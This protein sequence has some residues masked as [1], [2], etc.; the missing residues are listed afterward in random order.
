MKLFYKN[1]GAVTIFLILILVPVL[2]L[3]GIFVEISRVELAKPLITSSAD[4]ALNT[5][6]TNY[7]SKLKDYYGL[8]GSAQKTSDTL[9]VAQEYFKN[10]INSQIVDEDYLDQCWEKVSTV[11]NNG[12]K[13]IGRDSIIT[14][15]AETISNLLLLEIPELTV[16]GVD[17]ANLS[18]PV[19]LKSQIVEFMKYR[20]PVEIVT[21]LFEELKNNADALENLEKDKKLQ[22]YEQQT[23]EAENELLQRLYDIYVEIDSYKNDQKIEKVTKAKNLEDMQVNMCGLKVTRVYQQAHK[24][25]IRRYINI[26]GGNGFYTVF[27][28]KMDSF[29]NSVRTSDEYT[30][31]DSE[32]DI[33]K[34]CGQIEGIF[35]IIGNFEK[36]RNDMNKFD[37]Y[38]KTKDDPLQYCYQLYNKAP[39]GDGNINGIAINGY[40]ENLTSMWNAYPQISRM[41]YCVTK[42]EALKSQ[43]QGKINIPDT[44]KSILAKGGSSIE[45]EADLLHKLCLYMEKYDNFVWNDLRT[46]D[47]RGEYYQNV[48]SINRGSDD[49]AENLIKFMYSVSNS[50]TL[51]AERLGK[52]DNYGEDIKKL[53]DFM[54]DINTAVRDAQ[55]AH[56]DK[57][58]EM[59]DGRGEYKPGLSELVKKYS[60]KQQKW[61]DEANYCDTAGSYCAKSKARAEENR[62]EDILKEEDVTAFQKRINNID[63]YLDGL[64][65]YTTGIKCKINNNKEETPLWFVYFADFVDVEKKCIS[66]EDINDV[67]YDFLDKKATDTFKM[68]IDDSKLYYESDSSPDFDAVGNNLYD[69]MKKKFGEINQTEKEKVEKGN[70]RYKS[71]KNESAKKDDREEDNETPNKNIGEDIYK[72]FKDVANTYPSGLTNTSDKVGIFSSIIDFAQRLKADSVGTLKDARDSLYV[73]EYCMNMFSYASYENEMKY[74]YMITNDTSLKENLEKLPKCVSNGQLID[75]VMPTETKAT[76]D[77]LMAETNDNKNTTITANKTLT[78]QVISKDNN[79]A[80]QR[81]IEYLLYGNDNDTNIKNVKWELFKLRYAM[82]IVPG[83]MLFWDDK[84]IEGISTA[85]SGLTHGIVPVPLVK[86]VMI[87]ILIGLESDNDVKLLLEG[88]PV[89]LLKLGN[90]VDNA[91]WVMDVGK[92]F[93]TDATEL[94]VTG[95]GNTSITGDEETNPFRLQ[96]SDYLTLLLYFKIS[97]ESESGEA[98]T[99]YKRIGDVIQSNMAE[100]VYKDSSDKFK[101]SNCITQ[102]SLNY[103]AVVKPLVFNLGIYNGYGVEALLSD[104]KWRTIQGNMVRGY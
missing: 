77:G 58:R 41:D 46:L 15:E 94:S 81:E 49:T 78:N 99:V 21:G 71:Y 104:K 69:Y 63:S 51:E 24:N 70:N 43:L 64:V 30:Y 16:K 96:Y 25:A 83:Y 84:V 54:N 13:L 97:D 22:E 91:E 89:R 88:V 67:T 76:I 102:F 48:D 11:V 36:A 75:D 79:Y 82:N 35:P 14:T 55:D 18:N 9:D 59:I 33:N 12:A 7:D 86:V 34:I 103:S 8:M 2:A 72:S 95:S 6:L 10:C 57:I 31:T 29:L 66:S 4:L 85:V 56:L 28:A 1:N 93:S 53:L 92:K 47:N 100:K 65:D 74:K 62:T 40:V 27:K 23:Y 80:Y 19:F 87:L 20:A 68:E 52:D 3:S 44:V 42:D 17:N 38:T 98:N 50:E 73:V 61:E 101:L 60:I 26:E 90:S 5:A 45:D 39:N 37:G 32:E